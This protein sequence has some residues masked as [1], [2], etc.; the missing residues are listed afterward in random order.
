MH[1]I[2]RYGYMYALF[3]HRPGEGLWI[4]QGMQLLF[5]RQQAMPGPKQ[6][7]ERMSE[8]NMPEKKKRQIGCHI[9]RKMVCQK[10]C[11]NSVTGWRSCEER[12][13]NCNYLIFIVDTHAYT[14]CI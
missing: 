14:I 2:Y 5:Q 4:L 12:N 13:S 10:L 7:S 9:F 11:Q 3:P 6:M 8:Y 1:Y